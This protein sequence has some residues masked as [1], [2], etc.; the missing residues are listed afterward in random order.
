MDMKDNT[1]EQLLEALFKDY[2]EADLE[3]NGFTRRVMRQLPKEQGWSPVLLGRLWTATCLL[4]GVLAVWLFDGLQ[5]LQLSL[6]GLWTNC[7]EALKGIDVSHIS[8]LPVLGCIVLG[9]LALTYEVVGERRE[10]S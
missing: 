9:C 4:V 8:P 1:E 10:F 5:V 3:D 7:Y 6:A 2:K